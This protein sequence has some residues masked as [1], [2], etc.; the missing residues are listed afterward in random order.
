M[1]NQ[2]PAET[3]WQKCLKLPVCNFLYDI[4]DEAP[5]HKE[6]E[7]FLNTI[8][9]MRCDHISHPRLMNAKS[10]KTQVI[11]C[12]SSSSSTTTITTTTISS[13]FPARL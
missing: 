13:S 5:S 4:V 2:L 11:P 12:H 10:T 3:I 1:D 6:T 7:N 9:L 8:G